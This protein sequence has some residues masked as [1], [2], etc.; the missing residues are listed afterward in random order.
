MKHEINDETKDAFQ[1]LLSEMWET[2]ILASVGEY[3]NIEEKLAKVLLFATSNGI[4]E[5]S[6]ALEE[7]L[8]KDSLQELIN[9]FN[10]N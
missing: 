5:C 8:N 10:Q 3:D 2:F 7:D 6:M 1:W 4:T 9:K